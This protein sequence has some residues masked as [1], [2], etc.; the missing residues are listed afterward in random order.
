MMELTWMVPDSWNEDQLVN[1]EFSQDN[2]PIGTIAENIPVSTGTITW[3]MGR[4]VNKSIRIEAVHANGAIIGSGGQR[5]AA[6]YD[7]LR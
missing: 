3:S 1:L 4:A 2:H 5:A 7:R 6:A